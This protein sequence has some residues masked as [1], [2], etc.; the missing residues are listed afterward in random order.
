MGVVKAGLERDIKQQFLLCSQ[1]YGHLTGPL[2]HRPVQQSLSAAERGRSRAMKQ[3]QFAKCWYWQ[4]AH[5]QSI[6]TG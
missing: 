6:V 5:A 4:R 1:L 2:L 3:N